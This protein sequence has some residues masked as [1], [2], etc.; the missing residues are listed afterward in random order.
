MENLI[1]IRIKP[2]SKR[3][4]LI[5]KV[6]DPNN[7]GIIGEA[8]FSMLLRTVQVP[9]SKSSSLKNY[10]EIFYKFSDISDEKK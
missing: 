3:Y 6:L 9:G 7:T 1:D 8:E 4:W 2:Y 10:L 5:L